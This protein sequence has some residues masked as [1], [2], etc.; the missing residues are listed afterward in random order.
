MCYL[1]LRV[2]DVIIQLDTGQAG[3]GQS[4]RAL[5]TS[6]KTGRTTFAKSHSAARRRQNMEICVSWWTCM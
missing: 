5:G 6:L 1:S 3:S 4:D 2:T